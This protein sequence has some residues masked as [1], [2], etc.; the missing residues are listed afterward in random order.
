MKKYSKLLTLICALLVGGSAFAVYNFPEATYDETQKIKWSAVLD[1]FVQKTGS[2]MSGNL[3]L[4]TAGNGIQIKEGTNARMGVS[5][6]AS[7]VI[8]VSNTSVTSATRIFYSRKSVSSIAEMGHLY[9]SLATGVG[10]SINSS[11]N[12][13]SS[14]INWLLIEAP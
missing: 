3:I 6:L 14:V 13:D 1:L 9:A 4:G 10:F 11:D 12:L 7:G 5:T 8:Q 2:T